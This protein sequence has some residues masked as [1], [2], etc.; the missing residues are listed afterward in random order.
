MSSWLTFVVGII[1]GLLIGWVID[2]LYRRRQAS[3]ELEFAEPDTP[4][5]AWVAPLPDVLVEASTRPA[6][7]MRRWR[8]KH[9]SS[10]SSQ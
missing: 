6:D 7:A 9:R 1:F 5:P 10:P 3:R 2:L 4:P 8:R